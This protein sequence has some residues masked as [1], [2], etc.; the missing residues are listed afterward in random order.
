VR[1]ALLDLVLALDELIGLRMSN[2][3]R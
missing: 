1:F 3:A 2:H